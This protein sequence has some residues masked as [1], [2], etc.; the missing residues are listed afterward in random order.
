MIDLDDGKPV[1]GIPERVVIPRL[2]HHGVA[3]QLDASLDEGVG[4]GVDEVE[5]LEAADVEDALASPV[6]TPQAP[7]D[8]E[9]ED[10]MAQ[11]GVRDVRGEVR[12]RR[13]AAEV[14]PENPD[15][16]SR[17]RRRCRSLARCSR[18]RGS[19]AR[20]STPTRGECC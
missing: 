16:P 20:S 14:A 13:E 3:A 5:V 15:P 11:P 1:F 12:P 7:A 17:R 18:C 9:R 6:P 2:C 8:V 4:D 19:P 10:V